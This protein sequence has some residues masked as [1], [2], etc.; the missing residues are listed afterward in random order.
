MA[1]KKENSTSEMGVISRDHFFDLLESG[2]EEFR[3]ETTVPPGRTNGR[4]ISED[5]PFD[6]D[7]PMSYVLIDLIF[8]KIRM[9][10][11]GEFTAH[12]KAEAM[13]KYGAKTTPVLASK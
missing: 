12:D 5:A 6:R 4:V 13:S 2:Q 9:F 3:I 8:D 7:D 11:K 1:D 10:A